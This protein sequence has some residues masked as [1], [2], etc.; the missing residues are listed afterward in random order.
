MNPSIHPTASPINRSAR[1]Q[2]GSVAAPSFGLWLR[3]SSRWHTAIQLTCW[4]L[5]GAA[6]PPVLAA[7]S[8][9][10]ERIY[11]E[12][13]DGAYLGATLNVPAGPGPHPAIMFI[14]GGLGGSGFVSLLRGSDQYVQAHLFCASYAIFQIDY[15]RFAFGEDEMEDVVAGYRYLQKRAEID[16]SRIGVIGGSHG[17]YLA[18]ML[19][20]RVEPAATV[21][22][23]GLADIRGYLYDGAQAVLPA[24]RADPTW[25][26]KHYHGGKTIKEESVLMDQGRREPGQG[27][28]TNVVKEVMTDMAAR[29]ADDQALWARDN[30]MD[31]YEHIRGPLLFVAGS[32]DRWAEPG[33]KLVN[34]LLSLGRTA[35]FSLHPGM[36]HGFYWGTIPEPDGNLPD[37][38]YRALQRTTAFMHRWVKQRT[39]LPAQAKPVS[40]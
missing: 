20:T 31:Q 21:V 24:L 12:S 28:R 7:V 29:L 18:L 3:R 36:T 14:H 1:F 34:K 39:S 38:F 26:E 2:S 30:P 19:A 35:E 22:F 6:R 16:T 32:K 8:G 11:V 13:F 15:R 9:G 5:L 27:V 33:Q 37:E 23:V 40:P 17:G 10:E 25:K 4:L